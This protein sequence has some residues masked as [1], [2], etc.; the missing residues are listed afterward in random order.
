MVRFTFIHPRIVIA[1]SVLA[2]AFP[3]PMRADFQIT[4]TF[5][6]VSP[7]EIV[8]IHSPNGNDTTYAGDFNWTQQSGT[9][10]HGSNPNFT[11]FCVDLT[12]TIGFSGTYK[13]NVETLDEYYGANSLIA[14][15]LSKWVGTHYKDTTKGNQYAAAFQLGIWEIITDGGAQQGLDVLPDNVNTR[16]NF[17]VTTNPDNSATLAASWLSTIDSSS[18]QALN[19]RVLSGVD[20]GNGDHPQSQL[21]FFGPDLDI[22]PAPSSAILMALGFGIVGLVGF[23]RRRRFGPAIV[24]DFQSSRLTPL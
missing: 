8:T 1:V 4:A 24:N 10:L 9:N 15:R 18:S 7:G 19:L 6:S 23:A 12:H 11:T 16:G 13:Y 21:S 20:Y 5:H 14:L 3:A 17:Y 2:F 22:A